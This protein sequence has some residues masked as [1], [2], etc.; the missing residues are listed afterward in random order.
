MKLIVA[1]SRSFVGNGNWS[2]VF[3]VL[4][5]I[6]ARYPDVTVISGGAKGADACGERWAALR[7]VPCTVVPADWTRYGRA[8]GPIRNEEMAK[9]GTH[10][11]AVWDGHSAGTKHMMATARKYRLPVRVVMFTPERG[12]YVERKG[13]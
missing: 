7:G 5:G 9:Q 3:Q 12:P 8:A 1:G 13:L 11:L 2:F 4:D 6:R 10:L